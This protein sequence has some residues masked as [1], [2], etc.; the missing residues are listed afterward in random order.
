MPVLWPPEIYI[1]DPIR[2]LALCAWRE[3]RGESLAAKLGVTWTVKNRCAM[4]PAQGFK[5]DIAGNILHPWAFSS[6][7]AGDPNS[8]KYPAESDPS[9]IDSLAA[10][11][12][13]E[14]DPTGNAVFY[15]SRPLT[16]PPKKEDGTCAW[17]N[18]EHSATI[19]GLQFYRIA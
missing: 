19:D 13:V 18:V 16:A 10:A 4:A 6:F 9:W 12:S 8:L 1:N 5:P 7:M 14:A 11:K 15:F 2:L 3:A 17:G